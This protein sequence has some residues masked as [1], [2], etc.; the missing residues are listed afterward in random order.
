[1]TPFLKQRWIIYDKAKEM[2]DIIVNKDGFSPLR[3][4]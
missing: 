3:R 1:M 4:T 2:K